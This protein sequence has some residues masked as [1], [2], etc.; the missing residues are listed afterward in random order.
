MNSAAQLWMSQQAEKQTQV[1]TSMPMPKT[2]SP[3][4]WPFLPLGTALVLASGGSCAATENADLATCPFLEDS[5]ACADSAYPSLDASLV[6]RAVLPSVDA[7]ARDAATPDS[8]YKRVA[9]GYYDINHVLGTG[10][11]LSVGFGSTL[12]LTTVQPFANTMFVGGVVPTDS[13]GASLGALVPLTEQ[14]VETLSSA[15][16]NL[17]TDLARTFVLQGLPPGQTSHDMLISAHG[18]S[19]KTYWELKKNGQTAAYANGLAQVAAARALAAKVGKTYVVRAVTNV[20][21]ESDSNVANVGYLANLLEWQSDYETDVKAMTGQPEAVPMFETQI[22]SW[23]KLTGS[24]RLSIIP[25]QQLGAHLAA[26]GK[27]ILVGPKYHL[28]YGS[29]GIHLTSE[30]YQHMGEDYAKAYRRVILES[31]TWEPVRPRSAT[32]VGRV[33]TV[34]M[35]VPVPPLVLD[36]VSVTDP[37]WFGFAWVDAGSRPPAIESVV[38][39]GPDTVVVTLSGSPSGPNGKLRYAFTG[40]PGA[41]AGPTSGP[42][43]NLRDSDATPS[44]AGFPLF[45]WCVHFEQDVP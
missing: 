4:W 6:D 5:G 45:N 8:R 24:P 21:G 20:H 17:V 37:G 28:P 11:S 39:S 12:A 36:T 19:G 32:R 7:P 34:R 3:S 22:S 1:R 9:F 31:G 2:G 27:V 25:M 40:T 44:R 30:G 42:R 14:R 35:F 33:V 15:F 10:Q 23:T 13:G 43:G 41:P 26:P 18:I 38:V 29:D 16:G